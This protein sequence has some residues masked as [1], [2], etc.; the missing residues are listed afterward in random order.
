[1][2][3]PAKMTECR[4]DVQYRQY[5]VFL[6]VL[7]KGRFS[8]RIRLQT[9]VSLAGSALVLVAAWDSPSSDVKPSAAITLRAEAHL[10]FI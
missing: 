8:R 9:V 2:A 6:A 5:V 3:G 1:M 4:Q 7:L 10:P